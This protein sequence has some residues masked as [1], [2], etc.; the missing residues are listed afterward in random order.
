MVGKRFSLCHSQGKH[1]VLGHCSKG[2][3][4]DARQPSP[5]NLHG[6]VALRKK[7]S[8]RMINWVGSED[9]VQYEMVQ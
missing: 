7:G 4:M 9:E 6:D 3:V 5:H 2:T 1:S 8:M